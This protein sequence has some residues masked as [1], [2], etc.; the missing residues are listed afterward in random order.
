[1]SY[2]QLLCPVPRMLRIPL[3]V[4]GFVLIPWGR[5]ICMKKKTHRHHLLC[6]GHL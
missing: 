2:P 5:Y 3:D 1:M 6:K 4:Q